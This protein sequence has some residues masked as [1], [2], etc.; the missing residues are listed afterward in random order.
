MGDVVFLSAIVMFFA[1]MVGFVRMCDRIISVGVDVD[2]VT[3]DV[4]VI[5]GQAA[6]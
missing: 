4:T 3:V 5:D 1:L 6:A 2:D